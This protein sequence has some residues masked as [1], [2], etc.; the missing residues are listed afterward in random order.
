MAALIATFIFVLVFIAIS[1]HLLHETAAALLG[2]VAVFLVT[3][4][5]GNSVPELSILRFEDA[6][7]FVDWNVIFLILGMMI[8][9]KMR[10]V[11]VPARDNGVMTPARSR[12]IA[13][14]SHQA[15]ANPDALAKVMRIWLNEADEQT[16]ADGQ[17]RPQRNRRAA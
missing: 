15:M 8:L 1:F 17:A 14:L 12:Q 16:E 9:R 3:Y 13:E 2:A 7:T 5:G 6:M 10:P 11:V 4:I